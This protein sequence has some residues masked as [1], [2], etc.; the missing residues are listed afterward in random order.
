MKK[1]AFSSILVLLFLA[2]C[3]NSSFSNDNQSNVNKNIIYAD[4]YTLEQPE[5]QSFDTFEMTIKPDL[6]MQELY[7][8]FDE[9]VD[10]YYPNVFSAEEK[11]LL[12]DVNGEDLT[13]EPLLRTEYDESGS[14]VIGGY[15]RN[16]K[17]LLSGKLK[18]PWLWFNS[19]EGMIQM[20]PNGSLQSV[21]C[22]AAYKMNHPDGNSIGMYCAADENTVVDKIHVPIQ[23]LD[24]NASYHLLNGDVS[25]EDAIEFT[26]SNLQKTDKGVADEH[27]IADVTDAWI[28]DMGDGVYGYH[29]WLT[30]TYNGI[31]LDTLPMKQGL[32][33]H[34]DDTNCLHH[35][36][37]HPG[38]AFMV[39]SNK[40][41]SIMAF[42]F[43]RAYQINNIQ[44]HDSCLTY[45]NAEKKLSESLSNVARIKLS[46]TE[47]VYKPYF[48]SEE[49]KT[50][51]LS[52]NA[53]WKF[54]ATNENDGYDYIFYVDAISGDVEY[55]KYW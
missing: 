14:P 6:K 35:Y 22:G 19:A 23:G 21:T 16:K 46:R 25:L 27:F 41:D 37:L 50:D 34:T 51:H 24:N 17:E 15:E 44:S 55:Y 4:D 8:L 7:D 20:Y 38:Y 53:A 36:D 31:R 5:I 52:V 18:T 10:Q 45:E 1:Y 49:L 28:V 29:F 11:A 42:G 40:L 43:R 30:S 13:G 32:M 39:E 33:S 48:D 9:T 26:E 54:V 2:G 12:Y 47:F 3:Q